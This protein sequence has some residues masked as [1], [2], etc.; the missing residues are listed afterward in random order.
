MARVSTKYSNTEIVEYST[1]LIIEVGFGEN[2][3]TIKIKIREVKIYRY[4]RFSSNNPILLTKETKKE[5]SVGYPLAKF[6]LFP[7]VSGTDTTLTK[8]KIEI[9]L[10]GGTS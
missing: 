1:I 4:P 10:S 3:L 5:I 2:T 6:W 9:L 7:S 8:K